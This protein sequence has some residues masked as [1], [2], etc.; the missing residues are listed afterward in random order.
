MKQKF[1]SGNRCECNC[2]GRSTTVEFCGYCATSHRTNSFTK[3]SGRK[4]WQEQNQQH[5]STRE[6]PLPNPT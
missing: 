4:R 6:T 2:H 3:K 1:S 5:Q